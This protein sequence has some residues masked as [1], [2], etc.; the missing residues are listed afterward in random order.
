[1]VGFEENK[2]LLIHE[3]VELRNAIDESIKM[4]DKSDDL[5]EMTSVL[6]NCPMTEL[7]DRKG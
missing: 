5:M 4:I 7:L 3:L 1:M 6:K 2:E